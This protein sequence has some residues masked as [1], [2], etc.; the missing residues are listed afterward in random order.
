MDQISPE[1]IAFNHALISKTRIIGMITGGVVAGI[2]GLD[3][4]QGIL[5]YFLA[6]ILTSVAIWNSLN[7]KAFPFFKDLGSIVTGGLFS[8]V[9]SYLLFWVMFYNI[10]HIL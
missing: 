6:N 2:F 10:V 8:D 3:G 5:F 4:F 1:A 7:F 9:M